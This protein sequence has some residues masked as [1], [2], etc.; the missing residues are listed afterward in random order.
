MLSAHDNDLISRVGP[1]MPMGEMMRRYWMPALLSRELQVDGDPLRLML[2]GEALVAFR[3]SSGRVGIIDHECPHRCASLFYGRNE[4]GG[5]RCIYHGW[6]FDVA[7]HCLDMA[8]VPPHQDFKAKIRAKAYPV[9]E[10]GGVIWTY[11]GPLDATTGAPPPLPDIL[12]NLLP[13]DEVDFTLFQRECNWLQAHPGRSPA[14]RS[15]AL[16]H[17]Q[18]RSDL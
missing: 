1:G 12:A 16:R 4:E 3:D 8:N 2:L 11:M 6:K 10:R 5:L 9:Q 15:A 7:G 13:E 14:R 18:P 17:H